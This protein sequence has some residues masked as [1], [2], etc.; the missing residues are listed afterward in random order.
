TNH[1][2]LVRDA[3]EARHR[4]G[5]DIDELAERCRVEQLG[6]VLEDV[7]DHADIGAEIDL[8]V[9]DRHRSTAI[10]GALADLELTAQVGQE[11]NAADL[12]QIG[13]GKIEI[14]TAA[15]RHHW[16]DGEVGAVESEI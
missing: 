8:E 14:E 15:P 10:V 3:V 6:E 2:E 11:L 1:A 4:L 7:A 9:L 12:E 5:R 13:R 16:R